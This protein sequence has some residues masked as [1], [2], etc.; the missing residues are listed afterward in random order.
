MHELWGVNTYRKRNLYFSSAC[1]VD[2]VA[3]LP[4]DDGDGNNNFDKVELQ[5]TIKVLLKKYNDMAEKYHAE[6]ADNA[7]NSLVLG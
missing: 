6:K 1:I 5:T 4:D 7:D 2:L 3:E